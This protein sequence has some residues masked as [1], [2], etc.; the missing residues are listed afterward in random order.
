MA[1][2]QLPKVLSLLLCLT[3]GLLT[4]GCSPS[5]SLADPQGA[6]PS[7][8]PMPTATSNGPTATAVFAGGC[9]WCMEGPFDKLPG[10]IATTSGYTG[11]TKT[12][13][14]YREVSGGGTGHTESVQVTYDPTQVT[15]ETLLQTFWK[16]IDPLDAQGQF[17]DKGSQYRSGI[18][19]ATPAQQ[20]AAEASKAEL[21]K[22]GKLSG[23]IVTEVTAAGTFYPA[24]DY[25][26][27]YYK[28]NPVKYKV[29]RFGCGRDQRLE[30]LWGKDTT[31]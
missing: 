7:A 10:V 30:T 24:E 5:D 31:N 21:A 23:P 17:C 20:K 2:P 22:S 3:I 1:V 25:H 14:T 11:G 16:N 28:K 13:P 15:Y 8:S 4:L 27:D 26:Q 29:Y 6:T 18:F 9:F 12:N 19:Y